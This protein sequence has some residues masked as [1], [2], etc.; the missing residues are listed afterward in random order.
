MNDWWRNNWDKILTLALGGIV[1]FFSGI[2]A[3]N[4]SISSLNER[5]AKIETKA[6]INYDP[7]YLKVSGISL[8]MIGLE[9]D[10][11]NL[12]DQQILTDKLVELHIDKFQIELEKVRKET[13]EVLTKFVSESKII[14]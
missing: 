10:L 14:K 6:Q 7:G 4:H 11:K 8:K 12:K 9:N 5:V 3:T 2:I 13:I 1:G